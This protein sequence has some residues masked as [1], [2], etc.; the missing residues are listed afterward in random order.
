MCPQWT[1]FLGNKIKISRCSCIGSNHRIGSNG[2]HHSKATLLEDEDPT[3]VK[4][5]GDDESVD[6]EGTRHF[7]GW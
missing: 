7:L 1:M 5:K 2:N 3:V 6:D 4:P